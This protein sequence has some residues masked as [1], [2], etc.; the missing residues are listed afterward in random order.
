MLDVSLILELQNLLDVSLILELQNL[1]DV[2]LILE[3]QNL[4]DGYQI[5]MWMVD[6]QKW[7]HLVKAH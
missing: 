6:Y 4:L 7:S 3:L 2:S 1:L 5:Q